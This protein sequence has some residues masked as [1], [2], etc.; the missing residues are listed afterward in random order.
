MPL[1]LHMFDRIASLGKVWYIFIGKDVR[2]LQQVCQAS[3][4]CEYVES[5]QLVDI[6]FT[7]C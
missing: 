5:C 3:C 1:C 4:K 7:E 2:V 6:A